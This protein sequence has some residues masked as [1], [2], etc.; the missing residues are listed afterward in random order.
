MQ[1]LLGFERVDLEAGESKR[2]TFEF[3]TT[4]LAFHDLDMNLTVEEGPYEIRVGSSATDIEATEDLEV[5]DTKT[6][7]KTARTYYTDSAVDAE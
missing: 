6:V 7:P 3:N 5:T 4:Q 2:V 1:E